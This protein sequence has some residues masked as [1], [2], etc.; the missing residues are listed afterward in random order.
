[1]ARKTRVDALPEHAEYSDRGCE[2]HPSCLSCPL[3][4][5]RYDVQGGVQVM[6]SQA[7]RTAAVALKAD[8]RSVDEIAASIG[9]SRRTACRL[10]AE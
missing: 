8:G 2:Y 10:L 7:R 5:C 4:V 3:P 6:R 1:M 9:C